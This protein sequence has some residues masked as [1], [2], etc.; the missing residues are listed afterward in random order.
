MVLLYPLS[1]WSLVSNVVGSVL[2]SLSHTHK[3]ID[4]LLSVTYK[5]NLSILFYP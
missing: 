5:Q 1:L 2:C 3:K 4:M